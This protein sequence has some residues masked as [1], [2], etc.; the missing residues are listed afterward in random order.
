MKIEKIVKKKFRSR[1]TRPHTT[2][3]DS[4]SDEG[5]RERNDAQGPLLN[6][7]NSDRAAMDGDGEDTLGSEDEFVDREDEFLAH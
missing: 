4:D 2:W 7:Q 5:D 3:Y 6:N 1:L